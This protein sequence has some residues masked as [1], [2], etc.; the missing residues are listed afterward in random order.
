M[1]S[2]F[3]SKQNE[4][5]ARTSERE[6]CTSLIN[7]VLSSYKKFEWLVADETKVG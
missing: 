4:N 3:F 7:A 1:D 6:L 5:H 2:H